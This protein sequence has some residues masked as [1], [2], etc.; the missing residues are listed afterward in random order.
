MSNKDIYNSSLYDELSF[1][2]EITKNCTYHRILR[3]AFG[4]FL[5]RL[6]FQILKNSFLNIFSQF[7]SNSYVKQNITVRVLFFFFF[8]NEF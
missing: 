6:V 2:D 4:E 5:I 7:C 8:D 1:S 3:N